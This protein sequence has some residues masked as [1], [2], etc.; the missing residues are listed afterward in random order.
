[1]MSTKPRPVSDTER[2]GFLAF[3]VLATV[4]LALVVWPFVSSL[5]WA[6]LVAIIFHPLQKRM[7][8]LLGGHRN[9]AALVTLAIIVVGVIVPAIL[10]G[11]VVVQQAIALYT[12]LNYDTLDTAA[13]F[14]SLREALPA[15]LRQILDNSEYASYRVIEQNVQEFAKESIGLV[16][17]QAVAVGSGALTFVLALGIGIYV[18]YFF[19]R[20]GDALG[21]KVRN[22]LPLP[23]ATARRLS[24][25]FVLIVRATIKGSVVVGIVQG[26]LG[27][28]TFWIVGMPS[29]V[30]FGVL[31]ALFS[32]L[33]AV[34]PAIVWV[35]VA[36]YLLVTAEIW[37]G[38]VVILSGV[39]VIGLADN[40]LR[41]ILVGRDTGIPDW[42][43][44]ITTLGGIA[45]LGLSGIVLG[46]LAAGLFLAG[47]A[48]YTEQREGAKQA[49]Q[50]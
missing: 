31:M 49:G 20:D 43:V 13:M 7:L 5:L 19:L 30:L 15:S 2:T 17:Q 40:L 18:M 10:I 42:L 22:A 1:M 4:I 46:P 50:K 8:A 23:R 48:I 35:P 29:A 24:E 36:I 38:A 44:L 11:T 45:S 33:P 25:R 28:I 34:G 21:L 32:L 9:I 47:W 37:Q 12:S 3:L 27:T 6:T 39:L 14:A 26:A 41:P 16:A